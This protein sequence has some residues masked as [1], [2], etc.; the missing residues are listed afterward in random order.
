MASGAC[1]LRRGPPFEVV[2]ARHVTHIPSPDALTGGVVYEPKWD[3][4]RAVL[5]VRH[6]TATLWSRQGKELTR[7]FPDLIAAASDQLPD[8]VIID[9][10]A[11]VWSVGRL[12]FDALQRRLVGG[13]ARVASEAR[14]RPAFSTWYL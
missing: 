5:D 2:L 11:V 3:G 6:G 7:A 10:E 1:R 4:F 9:G 13:Q 12:D 8:G 14:A